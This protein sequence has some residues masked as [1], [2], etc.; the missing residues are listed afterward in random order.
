MRKIISSLVLLTSLSIN[1][2][3]QV[4]L[5][6]EKDALRQADIDFSNYSKEKGVRDAFLAYVAK[7]GVLLRPYTY[8]I[9]GFDAVKKFLNESD[10]DF[11]LTWAPSYAD[12]S[13]S[14][15]LG[16]TY[17][18]YELTFKDE[19]GNTQLRKGTYV[20]IWK[21]NEAGKWKFTLDTGNPGLEPKK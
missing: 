14:G 8:P 21:K 15:E 20:S 19:Q 5:Q 18:L 11:T 4:D 1:L 3:S 9:E 17:G 6:K 13:L 10:A 2:F 16:Y 12:V 7:D